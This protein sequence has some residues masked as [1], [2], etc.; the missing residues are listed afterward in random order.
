MS[1]KP[2]ENDSTDPEL[3]ALQLANANTY[4]DTAA[5]ITNPDVKARCIAQATEAQNVVANWLLSVSGARPKDQVQEI[6]DGLRKLIERIALHSSDEKKPADWRAE[7]DVTTQLVPTAGTL[8]T[9]S[10]V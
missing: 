2:M 5:L 4:L 6:E 9:N 1:E 10:G 8:S 3:M 7:G